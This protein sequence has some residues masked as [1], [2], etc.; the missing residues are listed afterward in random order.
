MRAPR[1]Y[2]PQT[3]EPGA[4]VQLD[5]VASNHAVRVLRLRGGDNLILFNGD[6]G[7]YPAVLERSERRETWARLRER[8]ERHSESPLHI[9]LVQAISKGE[10]MDY[11]IQKAVELGVTGIIPV[12]TRRSVV[13]LA[14]ERA[15]KRRQHWQQVAAS[16]CEQCGRNIVPGIDS[17]KNFT[18]WLATYDA[19]GLGLT[20][21]PRADRGLAEL[22]GPSGPITVLAGPEGGL[23]EQELEAAA[24]AG[25]TPLRLGPRVLRTETA[26]L[27]M[28]AALQ[29]LWGDLG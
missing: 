25:F 6:G 13:Q 2:T 21:D 23:D 17:P 3:L 16:A 15:E 5:P 27:A 29:A 12:F 19:A 11:T 20:M 18:Q 28:L 4:L 7:E 14:G 9:T 8:V 26:S 10:R 1:I 22:T 24:A